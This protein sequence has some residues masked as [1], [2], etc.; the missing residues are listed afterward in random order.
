MDAVQHTYT[1]DNRRNVI[2][3]QTRFR[4]SLE[5]PH[6]WINISA[7]VIR[8]RCGLLSW[9]Q[10]F[11]CYK[12]DSK[13]FLC[14]ASFSSYLQKKHDI[15]EIWRHQWRDRAQINC[16]W[17]QYRHTVREN[18]VLKFRPILIRNAR[19]KTFKF[20]GKSWCHRYD[21]IGSCDVLWSMHN[22]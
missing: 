4:T 13:H 17:G 8:F 19:E 12:Y 22:W 7:P 18:I 9:T 11:K 2:N 21:V 1:T 6:I 20:K 10:T 3:R 14:E 16:R 5:R 15:R